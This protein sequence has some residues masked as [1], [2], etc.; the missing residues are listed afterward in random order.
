MGAGLSQAR[1]Y[2]IVYR[3]L[4]RIRRELIGAGVP[5]T[6]R[7]SELTG[8]NPRGGFTVGYNRSNAS[9]G[10]CALWPIASVTLDGVTTRYY[11]P[12]WMPG[13]SW[14]TAQP[15]IVQ[16]FA[17]QPKTGLQEKP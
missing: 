4:H 11:G 6:Y 1:E 5:V 2:Q 7:R 8:Q 3:E 12:S 15:V 9:N 13:P 10:E 16:A 14:K 17:T